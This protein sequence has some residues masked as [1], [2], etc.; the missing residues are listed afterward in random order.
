MLLIYIRNYWKHFERA[1]A[2]NISK[3]CLSNEADIAA[4][5]TNEGSEFES[6]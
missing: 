6:Q 5:W 4:G 2:L 1:L 3:T